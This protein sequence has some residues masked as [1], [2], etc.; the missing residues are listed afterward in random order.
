MS[1]PLTDWLR[2]SEVSRRELA[3]RI[4][5]TDGAIRAIEAGG[6]ATLETAM[7]LRE[8]TGLP[9]TAFLPLRRRRGLTD[10]AAA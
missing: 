6:G 2:R 3:R 10:P 7:A 4:G 9:L 8:A 5:C 1:H